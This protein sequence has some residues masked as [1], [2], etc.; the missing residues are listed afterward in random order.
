MP[1]QNPEWVFGSWCGGGCWITLAI[2]GNT[3]RAQATRN[4]VTCSRQIWM[5]AFL[6]RIL[7]FVTDYFRLSSVHSWHTSRGWW[8]FTSVKL[9]A[10]LLP[11]YHL[12]FALDKFCFWIRS[13]TDSIFS[14]WDFLQHS[15]QTDFAS[16]IAHGWWKQAC[17]SR[18]GLFMAGSILFLQIMTN[19]VD[20]GLLEQARRLQQ[21][22]EAYNLSCM[23]MGS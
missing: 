9:K 16:F 2:S 15:G 13:P 10:I 11:T 5:I 23:D 12:L 19:N 18:S 20:S 14:D 17:A 7:T 6:I 22:I 8:V 4:N 3:A 21:S 1:I